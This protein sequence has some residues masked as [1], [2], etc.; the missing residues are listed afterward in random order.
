M[1]DDHARVGTAKA[2]SQQ[3]SGYGCCHAQVPGWWHV[4]D[5]ARIKPALTS[6]GGL[7]RYR[8]R[9]A[10]DGRLRCTTPAYSADGRRWGPMA[11]GLSGGALNT[12]I[13]TSTDRED[14]LAQ[15]QQ[16]NQKYGDF[17]MGSS[18]AESEVTRY[19]ALGR[20][21]RPGLLFKI[22]RV[23]ALATAASR[24]F[25]SSL[26]YTRGRR[27]PEPNEGRNT[28]QSGRLV[29]AH[30]VDSVATMI[31]AQDLRGMKTKQNE[32]MTCNALGAAIAKA[33]RSR[34]WNDE[35]Q[36]QELAEVRAMELRNPPPHHRLTSPPANRHA[37]E[38]VLLHPPVPERPVDPQPVSAD[39]PGPRYEMKNMAFVSDP[40][41][42]WMWS[43]GM[44]GGV[45]GADKTTMCAGKDAERPPG[46]TQ[47]AYEAERRVRTRRTCIPCGRAA[48]SNRLVR[49][50]VLLLGVPILGCNAGSEDGGREEELSVEGVRSRSTLF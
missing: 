38:V 40:D 20:P 19:P 13:R 8:P 45:C 30:P 35:W 31:M 11:L 17:P 15:E 2:N 28:Q 9:L 12:G 25:A 23:L 33:V 49:I 1:T 37:S 42:L 27:G 46:H 32:H 6:M 4:N 14:K 18:A 22:T 7:E 36:S 29:A 44:G 47:R 10:V 26:D 41:T 43:A 50:S 39:R 48:V 34:W 5:G 21:S 16:D 24:R 3:E